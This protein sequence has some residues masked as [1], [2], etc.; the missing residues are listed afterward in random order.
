MKIQ[1]SQLNRMILGAGI[2]WMSV[3]TNT[4]AQAEEGENDPLNAVVKLQVSTLVPDFVHP[5]KAGTSGGEGSGVVI[6]QGLVLTC[7]HCVA[8][9]THIRIRKQN[10]ETIY[11]GTVAFIDNDCD[12]ALVRVSDAAFMR[13]IE[14][15][16]LGDTSDVQDDVLAIGFPMGGDGIS[17]TRGIVSRIEDQT[18]SQSLCSLLAVQVDAAINHGNSGGPVL[19]PHD[20]TIVGIAFQGDEDG[21]SLG[22]MIPPEIIRHFLKDIEDGRV[23][24]FFSSVFVPLPLENEAARRCLGMKEGQTGTLVLDV[25]KIL[26]PDQIRPGDVVLEVDGYVVANNGNI[27]IEGNDRRSMSYPFYMRQIGESVPVKVLRDGEELTL[28]IPILRRTRQCRNFMYDRVPDYFVFGGYVFTTASY[29]FLDRL[30]GGFHD[31]VFDDPTEPGQ[32]AVVLTD[33]LADTVTDGCSW[34][35]AT[36]VRTV[37][38]AP[39]KNLRHLVELL[40]STTEEFVR[41]TLDDNTE[42]DVTLFLDVKQLREATPRIL[43]RYRIPADRSSDLMGK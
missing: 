19:N 43:E 5:W 29:N 37:N 9:S 40:S 12:L 41:L 23:D 1:M 3:A 36:K 30:N 7:A 18:Y 42:Y 6:D 21:E 32:E 16:V 13:D 34:A 4:F 2:V 8:D 15:M 28:S 38:G 10:E 24:G 20:G 39:V 11:E 26:G 35:K 22:Y 33:V 27:R 31:N 25:A 14:P 17:F